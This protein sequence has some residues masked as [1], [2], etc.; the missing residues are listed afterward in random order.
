MG[1]NGYRVI[2][3]GILHPIHVTVTETVNLYCALPS[4]GG[5]GLVTIKVMISTSQD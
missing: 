5:I 2:Y 4:K 3:R 1:L